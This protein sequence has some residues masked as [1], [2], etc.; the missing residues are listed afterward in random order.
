MLLA[1]VSFVCMHAVV[2]IMEYSFLFFVGLPVVIVAITIGAAGPAAYG[3]SSSLY[4]Q[5]TNIILYACNIAVLAHRDLLPIVAGSAAL[6]LLL[7][8]FLSPWLLVLPSIAY[9]L[10]SLP[11]FYIELP[12]NE[13]T[14]AINQVA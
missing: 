13:E 7:V 10:W 1:G 8:D 12:F 11:G 2:V 3:T 9:S 14:L 4:E 6:E 5:R